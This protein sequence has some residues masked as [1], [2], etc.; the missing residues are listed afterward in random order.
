LL[1]PAVAGGL[2][3]A[4]A[5]LAF[6]TWLAFVTLRGSAEAV[7]GPYGVSSLLDDSASGLADSYLDH[8]STTDASPGLD[9][10]TAPEDSGGGAP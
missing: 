10:G 9:P 2:A 5:G 7:A 3:A 8:G 4:M 1:Q 6:G